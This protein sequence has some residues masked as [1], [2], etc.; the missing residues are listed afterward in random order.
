MLGLSDEYKATTAPLEYTKKATGQKI[1]FRGADDPSKLKS[2]AVPF[3]HIG[4]L[5]FEEMDQFKGHESIR[6]IEQ[7]VIRGSD[8]AF[9]FKSF[10]PPRSKT[11]WANEYVSI[12]KKN[13]MVVWSNYTEV[14]EKW[15]GK[16]FLEEAEWIK[17][18]NPAAYEN[19]YMGVANGSGGQVFE[20]VN[21]RH[22][23]DEEI[24][25]FDR[26]GNGVDWGWFPD[27]W[28]FVRVQYNP[29]QRQLIIFDEEVRTKCENEET[30]RI[31][32]E[33]HG[34]GPD[35]LV[36]C[37]SA[38]PK[39]ISDYD[40]KYGLKARAAVKGPG[41]REYGFKWLAGLREIVIDP[42]RCPNALKEFMDYEF[43]RDEE[44]EFID[45]YPDGND[46]CIDAVRYATEQFS[47]RMATIKV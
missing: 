13:R 34:I 1:Y 46:H 6:K 41:S 14:P 12:P 21:P 20:N 38:E 3:G 10:N 40:A 43:E 32:R 35:D 31:L 18:I 5:W 47:K 25:S 30:A 11:N 17:E 26:I 44:G 9:I 33:E 29:A 4:I 28:A 7:S 36:I 37:D 23:S 2:I 22:I 24:A 45:G 19:E 15:L 16:P 39:S 42:T 8:K 27:P